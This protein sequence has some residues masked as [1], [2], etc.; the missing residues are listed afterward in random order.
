MEQIKQ[1]T[2]EIKGKQAAYRTQE[3]ERRK[4]TSCVRSVIVGVSQ[5]H[6][7]VSVVNII[8]IVIFFF[9]SIIQI[10]VIR[11]WFNNKKAI[12]G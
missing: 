3:E 6:E 4:S 2:T 1:M 8:E 10:F 12:L 7:R 9:F 11:R 5:T